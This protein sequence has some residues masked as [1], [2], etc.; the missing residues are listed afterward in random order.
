MPMTFPPFKL[1]LQCIYN[2]KFSFKAS[3]FLKLTEFKRK[4]NKSKHE[5][6]QRVTN[7]IVV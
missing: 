7:I 6:V 5:Y 2:P 1:I 3:S 4:D